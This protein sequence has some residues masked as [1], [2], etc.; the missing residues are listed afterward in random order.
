MEACCD[1]SIELPPVLTY[2]SSALM[3]DPRSALWS[4]VFTEWAV[5]AVAYILADAHYQYRLW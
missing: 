2:P 4:V 5:H 3:D 1:C